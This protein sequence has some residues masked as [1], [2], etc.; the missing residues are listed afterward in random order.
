MQARR[1]LTVMRAA[2]SWDD[3]WRD[4]ATIARWLEP[5]PT[6][7]RVA[8]EFRA[9]RPQCAL[10]LGCGPGRHVVLLARLG[11]ETHASDFSPAAVDHCQE[12]LRREGLSATVTRAD[13]ADIPQPDDFFDF[14]VAFNVIYHAT[15][16]GMRAM[17]DLLHRKLAPGGCLFVTLKS[18]ATWYYGHG[19]AIEP[20]TFVR[21]RR[22]RPSKD[23][24]VHFSTEEEADRLFSGF[25][26]LSKR[27]VEHVKATNGKRLA[28]WELTVRKRGAGARPAAAP[29]ELHEEPA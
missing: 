21:P 3:K 19:R 2:M 27:H 15:S 7:A 8:R 17:T 13:M 5:D 28:R 11:Y 12:R 4:P 23:V 9:D 14:I 26:I 18:P 10:D 6:V 22:R 20:G 25:E 1:L 24:P 29:R 16:A